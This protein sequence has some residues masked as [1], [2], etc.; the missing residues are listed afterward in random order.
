MFHHKYTVGPVRQIVVVRNHDNREIPTT[1]ELEE[2]VVK[3][4]KGLKV[5]GLMNTQF[6]IQG[7][8]RT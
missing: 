2:Q 4:A 8:G 6:A 7:E 3:L 5:V 1:T